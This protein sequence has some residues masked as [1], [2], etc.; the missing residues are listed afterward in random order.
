MKTNKITLALAIAL[1]TLAISA[2]VSA[3]MQD[4]MDKMDKMG[5][6]KM[7][8]KP[9]AM[10]S[11]FKGVEVNAGTISLYKE[12]MAFHLKVSD[13]FTIPAAPAPHWQVIDGKGHVYLLSRFTIAGDK[14]HRDIVLP[15][16]INS[17]SKVQV[18]C[19][20][21]EVVLGEAQF[22]KSVSLK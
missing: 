17:V 7:A 6:M 14:T 2:P 20:Y 8:M 16:Y 12:G 5:D 21:A 13:D 22:D 9:I 3:Q 19:S 11:T 1:G 4:N 10:T 18:Y 15:H